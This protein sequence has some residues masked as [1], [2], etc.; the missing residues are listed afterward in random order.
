M[1]KKKREADEAKGRLTDPGEERLPDPGKDRSK[2]PP[3]PITKKLLEKLKKA[4]KE[5]PNIYPLW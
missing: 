2:L 3:L 1:K 5:D 4:R